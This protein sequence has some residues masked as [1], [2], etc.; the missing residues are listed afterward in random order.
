MASADDLHKPAT[1]SSERAIALVV[2]LDETLCRSDT[3]YEA[4]LGY[5]GE[6]PISGT[7]NLLSWLR[8][9][10]AALKEELAA[11]SIIDPSTMRFNED[12]LAKIREAR[13]QGRPTLLVSASAQK[14]VTAVARHLG[15]FDE[16]VGTKDGRNLGGQAKAD[17]LTER[18]GSQG[19]DY[20]GDAEADLK[21][22]QEAREVIAVA[23][24]P[25]LKEQI[26]DIAA[27]AEYISPRPGLSEQARSYFRAIRPH[28]WLKNTLIFTPPLAAHDFSNIGASIFAFIAFCLIASSVYVVND[29]LDIQSDRAHPRKRKRPFAACEIPIERGVLLAG[30]LAI[31]AVFF[32]L[33]V[34][35]GLFLGVLA[36][37]YVTTFAYSFVLKRKLI[38]DVWTLAGLYTLR[39][40]AGAAATGIMLSLWFL[41]FS[42]FLFLALATVKR[43]SELVDLMRRNGEKATGRAYGVGD[44]PVLMAMSIAAGYCAVLVFALYV[45]S[46]EV[47]L[48]YSTPY[49]LWLVCPLLLYWISRVVMLTHRGEM[50]DDPIVFAIRDRNS[51][52]VGGLC[53]VLIVGSSLL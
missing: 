41:G 51:L 49:G 4:A 29:L 10:K 9:G 42:L 22:W 43:H 33:L 5:I 32:A 44:I 24:S 52:V 40:V 18:F 23:A 2:D 37:Y 16:A 25:K 21:V 36:A 12:V 8:A 14:Q 7:L 39:I 34:G 30:V 38:L 1:R 48:L 19:F 20:I 46:P 6:H 26:A 28:Q 50:H 31:G 13:Q 35:S 11:H 47:S 27:D 53:A 3:L 15:L 45:S 17:Y